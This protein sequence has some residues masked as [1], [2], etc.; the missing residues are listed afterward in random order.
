[1]RPEGGQ[2]LHDLGDGAPGVVPRQA[3]AVQRSRPVDDADLVP[4]AVA[5]DTDAVAGLLGVQPDDAVMDIAAVEE[6]HQGRM[7]STV[8][9]TASLMICEARPVDSASSLGLTM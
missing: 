6:F 4:R 3:A 9:S 2:R 5:Q 8:P 1:M 7:I